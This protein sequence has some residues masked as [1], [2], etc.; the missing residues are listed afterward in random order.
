MLTLNPVGSGQPPEND[1][2][3]GL[4]E[5]QSEA[6]RCITGP[7]LIIAGA[8][9]GKT[10]VLTVRLAYMLRSG[11]D[12]REVLALTPHAP[13]F[14]HTSGTASGTHWL[15]FMKPNVG[16]EAGPTATPT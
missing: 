9:S 10:R 12:P 6:V 16:S 7:L 14:G 8:G 13:L 4:N 11:I 2:L 15:V 5:Q 3:A 1:L